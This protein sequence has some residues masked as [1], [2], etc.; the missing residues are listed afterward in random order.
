MLKHNSS[1]SQNG[2]PQIMMVP[3]TTQIGQIAPVG[4]GQVEWQ[5]LCMNTNGNPDMETKGDVHVVPEDEHEEKHEEEHGEE[6]QNEDMYMENGGG[7][8]KDS[9]GTPRDN[10]AD[11]PIDMV[12]K[13]VTIGSLM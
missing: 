11:T 1:V 2:P 7:T 9:V 4:T 13:G 3:M 8:T 10:V 5:D 6:E 12:S